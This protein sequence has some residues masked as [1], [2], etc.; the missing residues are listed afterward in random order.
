MPASITVSGFPS[1]FLPPGVFLLS[2][3]GAGGA[4][5]GTR[6][7][8][9]VILGNK[10]SSAL[11]GSAPTFAVPAG[12]MATN[13]LTFFP[14]AE[15]AASLAGR[16]SEL[17]RMALKFFEQ[18]PTGT[19]YGIAVPESSSGS[20]VKASNTL[21][22]VS[23]LTGRVTLRLYVAGETIP[24]SFDSLIAKLVVTGRDRTQA[25]ERSRRALAEFEVDGMPTVIPFHRAVVA[26]PAFAPADPAQPFTVSTRWIET[27]F[28]NT[29]PAWDGTGAVDAPDAAADAQWDEHGLRGAA[30]PGKSVI[31]RAPPRRGRSR[32][33]SG[34]QRP[35][36]PW[37]RHRSRQPSARSGR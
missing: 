1:G 26:D 13:A 37:S 16:G 30:E 14:S 9:H 28:D 22:F 8:K 10:L 7:R 3:F 31:H 35:G 34:A 2:L 32:R 15:D 18:H 23:A 4:S 17:H 33:A 25:L 20:P 11:S 29:I 21:T 6:S 36:H 12:T 24:G 27:E 19:L 5:A